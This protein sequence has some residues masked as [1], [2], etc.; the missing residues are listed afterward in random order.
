MTD[1]DG[2]EINL[3]NFKFSGD[4]KVNY[5]ENSEGLVLEAGYDD[6]VKLNTKDTENSRQLWKKGCPNFEGYFMI[7]HSASQMLLTVTNDSIIDTKYSLVMIGLFKA[8]YFIGICMYNCC[9]NVFY[10]FIQL[11]KILMK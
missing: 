6:K 5:I 2:N 4:D 11:K 3:S 8:I 7:E 9:L 1:S 10:L